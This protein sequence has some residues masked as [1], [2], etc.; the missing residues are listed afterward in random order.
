MLEG[1]GAAEDVTVPLKMTGLPGSSGLP[2]VALKVSGP[3][4]ESLIKLN[5]PNDDPG[6][7]SDPAGASP[8]MVETHSM[9][10][11][12]SLMA[13]QFVPERTVESPAEGEMLT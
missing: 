10:V 2:I 11:E 3:R 9:K 12:E 7:I 6:A 4:S 13:A 8:G 1:S 5:P